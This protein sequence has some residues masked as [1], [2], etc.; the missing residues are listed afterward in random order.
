MVHDVP[1]ALRA[2]WG[3]D[4][5]INQGELYA[6]PLTVSSVPELLEGEDVLWWIDNTSAEAALVKAG[7][8]TESMCD[9]ALAATAALAGLRCRPWFDHVPSPDNPAD[10]LSRDGLE[11]ETVR[12]RIACGAYVVREAVEPPRNSILDYEYWWRRQY[13]VA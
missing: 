13:D 11:D 2:T 3:T 12:R 9:I 4:A 7:S 8:P 10:A 1:D 5:A 6:A